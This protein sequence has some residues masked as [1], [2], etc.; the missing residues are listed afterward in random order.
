MIALLTV[1]MVTLGTAALVLL[2]GVLLAESGLLI[3]FLLPGDSLLSGHRVLG[4]SGD[5]ALRRNRPRQRRASDQV[6]C[7]Y[8]AGQSRT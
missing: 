6:G 3:G 8:V 5:R 2:R 7:T 4:A 1:L